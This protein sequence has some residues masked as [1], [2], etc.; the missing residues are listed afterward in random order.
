MYGDTREPSGPPNQVSRCVLPPAK[1]RRVAVSS[2]KSS[3]VVADTAC[4][5]RSHSALAVT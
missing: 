3:P 1:V 2:P 5:V 4:R